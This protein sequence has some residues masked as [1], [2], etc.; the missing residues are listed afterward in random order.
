MNNNKKIEDT[1]NIIND[2]KEELDF[3]NY[4]VS[5]SNKRQKDKLNLLR[6]YEDYLDKMLKIQS[7]L[8]RDVMITKS[9]NK[10]KIAL[11]AYKNRLQKGKGIKY[12]HPKRNAYEVTGN[13][14][15]FTIDVTKF[16]ERDCTKSGI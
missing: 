6:E 7:N 14:G 2:I 3:F 1:E 16:Y 9:L 5:I 15:K 4:D 8:E 12:K 13:Y 10:Y 11:E